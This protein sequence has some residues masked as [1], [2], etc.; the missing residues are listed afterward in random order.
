MSNR[1]KGK[2]KQ[3]LNKWDVALHEVER[4]LAMAKQRVQQLEVVR[5]NWTRMRD[6]GMPWPQSQDQHSAQQH[7][8]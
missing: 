6:E 2:V 7:S 8:V 3:K 4:H 1:V 5:S